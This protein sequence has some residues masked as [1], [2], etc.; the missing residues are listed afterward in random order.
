MT[1]AANS[2]RRFDAAE[3]SVVLEYLLASQPLSTELLS[4]LQERIPVKPEVEL[5]RILTDADYLD[6][7]RAIAEQRSRCGEDAP[8]LLVQPQQLSPDQV[9]ALFHGKPILA[10]ICGAE[11]ILFQD[12]V[13]ALHVDSL[14]QQRDAAVN[15]IGVHADWLQPRGVV[16][17]ALMVVAGRVVDTLFAAPIAISTALALHLPLVNERDMH[18]RISE[19]CQEGGVVELNRFTTVER[20]DDKAMTHRLWAGH[21]VPVEMPEF[22]VI[23]RGASVRLILQEVHAMLHRSSTGAVY[24]QPNSGTEGRLVERLTRETEDQ[25]VMQTIARI[26]REDAAIVRVERGN[27]RY[28]DPDNVERGRR[29]IVFRINVA[30]DGSSFVAE[31]GYAQVA[32]D[33]SDAVASRGRDGEIVDINRAMSLLCEDRGGGEWRRLVLSAAEIDSIKQAA[34]SAAAA[35][36]H[37]LTPAGYIHLLGIDLLLEGDGEAVRPVLLEANP[38][39]AGLAHSRQITG[40][41]SERGKPMVARGLFSAM[42]VM[43]AFQPARQRS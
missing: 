40:I 35:I 41:S 7:V 27:V 3:V 9:A 6:R 16:S 25:K 29:R 13:H 4:Q 5:N 43:A 39:P 21:P 34:Q 20:A 32:R 2:D 1:S 26:H 38:R 10:L 19:W 22:R 11:S 28:C 23:D 24:V 14:A 17:R 33:E 31:S 15:V 42:N 37:G 36:H 30:W 18:R 8:T 12:T